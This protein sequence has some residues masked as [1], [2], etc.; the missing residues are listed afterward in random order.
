MSETYG[1]M[2][3]ISWNE[4]FGI[5]MDQYTKGINLLIPH[6]VWYNTEKVTFLPELS[7]RN[8]LYADSL[9][10]FTDYLSRLNAL[11]QNDARWTGDVAVLYPVHTMQSGHY[12]DG[13]LG[14]YRGGVEI[15]GLDYVDVGV[16]LSDSLGYDFMFLHPEV[17]DERC[18]VT[19]NRLL[20]ENKTQYNSFRTVVI[21][22]CTTV[23]LSNLEKIRDFANAGGSV[24]F[25]SRLPERATVAAD[26]GKVVALTQELINSRKAVFVETPSPAALKAAL[27]AQADDY[28]L[29]FAGAAA[30]RNIHK[31]FGGKNLWFFANPELRPQTV[32]VELSGA[33]DL[34]AW[35]PH[36]GTIREAV[37]TVR[38]N[39]KTCFQLHLEGVKSVFIM[40]K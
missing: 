28:S 31:I 15:P 24:I 16:A 27:S 11:L 35:N 38:K 34:E 6:A 8:P 9:R 36:T 29:T 10:L 21:P 39:G 4:I 33:Y 22:A 32:E 13:P 3:N 1:A 19:D 26:D 25:T 23:S 14:Y 18:R 5:A 40:E 12:M 37:K 30:L 17:L 20:L 7:L 2:G